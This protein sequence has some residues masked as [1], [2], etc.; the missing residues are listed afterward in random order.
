[1]L[2]VLG[3]LLVEATF[4]IRMCRPYHLA[5]GFPRWTD[6]IVRIASNRWMQVASCRS[7]RSKGEA[8]VQQ[9]RHP[10]PTS[11]NY[12]LQTPTLVCGKQGENAL[13]TLLVFVQ[14]CYN[15]VSTF[16]PLFQSPASESDSSSVSGA[17]SPAAAPPLLQHLLQLQLQAQSPQ[18][19]AQ[20]TAAATAFTAAVLRAQ[21]LQ[22]IVQSDSSFVS[23]AKSPAVQAIVQSDSSSVSGSGATSPAAAT[24]FSMEISPT[25]APLSGG[26]SL[27]ALQQMIATLA[28]LNTGLVPPA[29]SQAWLMQRFTHARLPDRPYNTENRQMAWSLGPKSSRMKTA[30][31]QAQPSRQHNN[32][33]NTLKHRAGNI[34]TS[35]EKHLNAFTTKARASLCLL[36]APGCRESVGAEC[37]S[38]LRGTA[39]GSQREVYIQHQRDTAS[40]Q[41]G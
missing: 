26:K 25:A 15:Q 14:R 37:I 5:N 21:S 13:V 33:Q 2:R 32:R 39:S 24:V 3:R 16:V 40:R 10:N 19:I 6:D 22:A 35:N 9:A 18:A 4:R 31:Q 27:V 41:Q 23:G 30:Y 36:E 7:Q 38:N 8:F 12:E 20:S 11:A 34:T 17:K 28:A 1:M 29:L